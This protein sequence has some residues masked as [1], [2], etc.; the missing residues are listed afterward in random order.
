MPEPS[1]SHSLTGIRPGYRRAQR[2]EDLSDHSGFGAPSQPVDSSPSR[3][4]SVASLADPSRGTHTRARS[5]STLRSP[6]VLGLSALLAVALLLLTILLLQR[7]SSKPDSAPNASPPAEA[8]A[9]PPEAAAVR[10]ASVPPG[11]EVRRNGVL[12]G[13][14]PLALALPPG[15]TWRVQ[16]STPGHEPAAVTIEAGTLAPIVRLEPVAAVAPTPTPA[17]RQPRPTPSPRATPTPAVAQPTPAPP[18]VPTP[19]APLPTPEPTPDATPEPTPAPRGP[20]SD[21]RNPWGN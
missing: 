14:T 6:A 3:G 12:L 4:S 16:L 9:S 2:T 20:G 7:G 15:A 19:A 18:P 11:A 5:R 8:D 1:A 21:L 10:L 17:A 13:A